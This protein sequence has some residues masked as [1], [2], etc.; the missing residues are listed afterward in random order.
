MAVVAQPLGEDDSR[1]ALGPWQDQG[2]DCGGPGRGRR[3]QAGPETI[4]GE[5]GHQLGAGGR[6]RVRQDSQPLDRVD[7]PH[8]TAVTAS[9]FGPELDVIS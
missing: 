1:L 7:E 8:E 6:E 3:R 4:V 9:R 5:D 2:Q